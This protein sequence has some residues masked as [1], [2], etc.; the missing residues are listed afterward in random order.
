MKTKVLVGILI[1]LIVAIAA[2]FILYKGHRD[3]ATESAD[4]VVTV[5]D[6]EN[7][8]IA[9][10]SLAGNK[11]QDKTIELTSKITTVDV[12]NKGIVLDEKVF[13]TFTDSL[14][15]EVAV[16]KTLKIKGRFLGYDELLQE[17]KIDQIS[18]VR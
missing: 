16:G 14:P 17:F 5:Q 4:Y 10:D 18:I 3:I 13:A 9:N 2:Y 7:E 11:Y 1:L 12:E 15:K 8:F 6:L